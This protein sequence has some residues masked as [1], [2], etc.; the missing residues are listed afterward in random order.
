MAM[1]YYDAL[2]VRSVSSYASEAVCLEGP[3]LDNVLD[4]ITTAD[5]VEDGVANYAFNAD[6][7]D[8]VIDDFVRSAA[9]SIASD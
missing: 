7:C 2:P 3:N 8:L 6:S 9:G 5:V 1:I 4:R